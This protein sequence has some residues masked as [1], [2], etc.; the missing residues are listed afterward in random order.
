MKI[1]VK[2]AMG[3]AMDASV[4]AAVAECETLG[5]LVDNIECCDFFVIYKDKL[6]YEDTFAIYKDGDFDSDEFARFMNDE[7]LSDIE[8]FTDY[9]DI[10]I[11]ADMFES[12]CLIEV[13]EI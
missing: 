10:F 11:K 6:G 8:L 13:K 12:E 7:I 2:E 3:F 1:E 4:I 5:E 9:Y